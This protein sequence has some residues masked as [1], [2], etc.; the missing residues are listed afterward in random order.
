MTAALA[1]PAI[2]AAQL[3]LSIAP[4]MDLAEILEFSVSCDLSCSVYVHAFT[5]ASVSFATPSILPTV[6]ADNL[7]KNS[8]AQHGVGT[9]EDA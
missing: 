5:H 2:P 7:R 8:L 4:M 3:R 1:I 6:I 9:N